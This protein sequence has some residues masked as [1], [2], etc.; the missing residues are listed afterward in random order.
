MK[1]LIQ[2]T[3]LNLDSIE[4]YAKGL[5]DIC[6]AFM[7]LAESDMTAE[8]I[9]AVIKPLAD[10]MGEHI[11]T[12]CNDTHQIGKLIEDMQDNPFKGGAE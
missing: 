10:S 9:K 6:H 4:I 1:Q 5:N 7:Q 12:I 11:D 2:K 3:A 8:Q